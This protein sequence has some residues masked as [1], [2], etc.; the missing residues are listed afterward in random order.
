MVLRST[1][2]LGKLQ[3]YGLGILEIANLTIMDDQTDCG[4]PFLYTTNTQ[5]IWHDNTFVD[6]SGLTGLTA[7]KNA[8]VLGGTS[9]TIGGGTNAAFQGYPPN[10]YDNNFYNIQ[11]G[12]VCQSFCNGGHFHGNNFA[13][14]SGSSHTASITAATNANPAVLTVTHGLTTADGPNL[15]FKGFTGSWTALNGNHPVT[16]ID[17]THL[18]VPINSTSFGALTGTPGYYDGCAIDMSGGGGS[19]GGA[20]GNTVNDNLVE[21]TY[22]PCLVHEGPISADNS[23]FGNEIFD[24]SSTTTAYYYKIDNSTPGTTSSFLRGQLAGLGPGF[25]NGIPEFVGAGAGV[26]WDTFDATHGNFG[27]ARLL[28]NYG[29]DIG[30]NTSVTSPHVTITLLQT[31]SS[32]PWVI[33]DYLHVPQAYIDTNFALHIASIQFT[34][35][36]QIFTPSSQ[37]MTFYPGGSDK[38]SYNLDVAN[39]WNFNA[40]IWGTTANLS[41]AMTAASYTAGSTA[42]VSC[43][44]NT[45]SLTTLVVTNGIVTHC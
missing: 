6:S 1:S 26:A 29:L 33:N 27:N 44:A 10:I 30:F 20:E 41:G 32:N 21:M 36:G 16:V 7:C 34:G 2:S 24:T 18:S 22:Y 31:P 3:T 45:V 43:A 9:T 42:G 13:L 40:A 37:P 14:G 38:L 35:A 19:G 8:M 15:I 12:W 23:Y 28:T 5:P 4:S 25:G 17:S 39:A 11:S